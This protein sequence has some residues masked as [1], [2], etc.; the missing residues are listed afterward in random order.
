MLPGKLLPFVALL[1]FPLV[2][3]AADPWVQLKAGMSRTEAT[4]VLGAELFCAQG[5]GFEIAIY[6][7]QAE[8][9]FLNG[10]VVAWTAPGGKP[11]A[12]TAKVAWQFEQGPRPRVSLPASHVAATRRVESRRPVAILPAYRL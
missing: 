12:P 3:A 7:Q 6:D 9:V 1:L 10:Q 5:R 8:V 4:E 11:P 2:G